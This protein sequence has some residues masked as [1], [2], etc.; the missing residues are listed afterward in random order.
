M[1]Y[2]SKYAQD[3]MSKHGGSDDKKKQS[4]AV[5][6]KKVTR[7]VTSDD[8]HRKITTRT[9]SKTAKSGRTVDKEK[10]RKRER[11]HYHPMD[12]KTDKKKTT[13]SKEGFV[14]V[15]VNKQSKY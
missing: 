11:G 4:V 15:K 5:K 12:Y 6:G 13:T 10:V 9:V 14:K 8:K 1:P 2:T 7:T 3:A